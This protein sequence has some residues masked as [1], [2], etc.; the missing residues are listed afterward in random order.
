MLEDF[1]KRAGKFY[2]IKISNRVG[3]LI[4]EDLYKENRKLEEALY[5][6]KNLILRDYKDFIKD[7]PNVYIF[8]NKEKMEETKANTNTNNGKQEE[9]V[10][11]PQIPKFAL[12]RVILPPSV[13]EDILLSLTDRESETYL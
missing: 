7:L 1:N 4:E 12:E 9:M 11:I 2:E 3:I 13:K 6:R 5:F 8:K 10:F